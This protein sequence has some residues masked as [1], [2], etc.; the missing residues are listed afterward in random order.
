MWFFTGL[1][2]LLQI[3][4]LD[5]TVSDRWFYFPLVGLLGMLGV[6]IAALIPSAGKL[7]VKNF[8]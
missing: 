2:M 3:F 4:P 5:M 6:M 7:K 8:K 1:G